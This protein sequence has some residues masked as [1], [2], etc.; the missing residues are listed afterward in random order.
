MRNSHRL[1]PLGLALFATLTAHA[2]DP[3]LEALEE[4]AF[5][6][7]AALVN[8]SIV[9]IQTVGGLDVVG[10]V[11]TPTGPTTG[12]V[13]SDDGYI[14]SSAFNF[15]SK[16]AS[17]LVQLFDGRRFPAEAV[18][19]DRSKMLTLLK[20]DAKDLT[21]VKEASKDAIRVG[22]WSLALGR[23]FDPAT[24]SV[25]VGIVSALERIWGR[26]I[27]T[28]AKVSPVNYGGPL[29]DVE[30]NV[31][32]VL[33]PLS[34]QG[35]G[36]E[37]AGVEWYDS[38][39]GFA[40]PMED[41]YASLDRLKA[42]KDLLPGLLGIE[43]AAGDQL[44]GKALI[45]RVRAESP[46]DKAGFKAGDL[47]LEVD[48]RKVARQADVRYALGNKYAGDTVK[49]TV[50]R[51]KKPITADVTLVAELV[52]Y[53]SAFLGILPV[54][55]EAGAVAGP[56]VGVRYVFAGSPAEKAGLKTRDRVLRFNDA[57]VNDAPA[58]LDLVG[59]LRPKAKASI[60]YFRDGAEK[61][62]E[63]ELAAIPNDIPAELPTVS[64]PPRPAAEKPAANKPAAPAR[65]ADENG[66]QPKDADKPADAKPADAA[67]R[68]GRFTH[69]MPAHEHSYWA[70]V[71]EDYN[72]A[73][74]YGLMVWIHPRNDTMEA[75]VF[76]EWKAICD[77][78]GLM[79]L[80]PKA[81]KIGGWELN[82]AEFVKEALEEFVEQYPIDRRRVFVHS[83][84]TGG[85]FA[86]HLA[87][88][89]RELFP[90]IA[91]AAAPMLNI[92]PPD[93]HPNFRQQF[94]LVCGD[95]DPSFPPV[96]LTVNGL[97]R[98]KFPASFAVVKDRDHKY[99]ASEEL[100][101]IGRWADLLDRI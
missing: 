51:D 53:E 54:R 100:Q 97:R 56:G 29:V 25:S 36:S 79:I 13:V 49:M 101:E 99:P 28:D 71:P 8:P 42:G 76:K 32:G 15:I 63:V 21:P 83:Y 17:I 7:A 20:I 70:Y 68:T 82:E 65:D 88:K 94:H 27:Q 44:A 74:Q 57:E 84:S 61:T 18:A 89:Y 12:V 60:A 50:E 47:I 86:Y 72:P 26:A 39:I 67:P 31:L 64:I 78:R 24:P 37:T 91:T 48:G 40:I 23:T 81:E 93:N 1:F 69:E 3:Q 14:I 87:F 43:F 55:E 46:A 90:G 4:Q 33:V 59:R 73:Y 35:T 96:Q 9:R 95:K 5:K 6:Q 11:L 66:A 38:G 19:T 52:P 34:P 10:Q 85:P 16:P 45:D 75:A 2:A 41:V 62:V 92:R 22:Q 98:L 58:L 30:G 77:S 80:A